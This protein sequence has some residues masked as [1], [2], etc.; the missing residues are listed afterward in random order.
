MLTDDQTTFL[1]WSPSGGQSIV[2]VAAAPVFSVEDRTDCLDLV[3]VMVLHHSSVQFGGVRVLSGY[4]VDLGC[5]TPAGDPRM[6]SGARLW[7]IT[8][9]TTPYW[10][11]DGTRRGALPRRLGADNRP[12]LPRGS[13]PGLTAL[14]GPCQGFRVTPE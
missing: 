4:L 7:P 5:V 6:R 10:Q 8:R 3:G 12:G 11:V 9:T 13:G 1:E 2:R 14:G